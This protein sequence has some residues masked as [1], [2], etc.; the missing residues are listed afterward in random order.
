MCVPTCEFKHTHTQVNT[1]HVCAGTGVTG[2]YK[3]PSRDAGNRTQVFMES[4][5]QHPK[6]SIAPAP[7]QGFIFCLAMYEGLLRKLV[8]K[9]RMASGY[10]RC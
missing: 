10:R 9:L 5:E 1:Y 3:L 6:P 7:W 4:S 2:S 8:Q